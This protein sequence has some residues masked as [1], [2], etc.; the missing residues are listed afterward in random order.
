M[1]FNF[2]TESQHYLPAV[3]PAADVSLT[4]VFAISPLLE[5][6]VNSASVIKTFV[7]LV[8][9][10]IDAVFPTFAI[11]FDGFVAISAKELYL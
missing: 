6:Q 11:A 9:Q 2:T 8:T 4:T 3:A 5:A 10:E 7:S 1:M